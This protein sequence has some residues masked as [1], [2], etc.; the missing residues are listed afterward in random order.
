MAHEPKQRRDVPG[1]QPLRL[2]QPATGAAQRPW[3]GD[4]PGAPIGAPQ[5]AAPRAR[6]TAPRP[7]DVQPLSDDVLGAQRQ[8]NWL[9]ELDGDTPVDTPPEVESREPVAP[10]TSYVEPETTSNLVSRALA[11]AGLALLVSFLAVGAFTFWSSGGGAGNVGGGDP[12]DADPSIVS[13]QRRAELVAPPSRGGSNEPTR[14]GALRA[15]ATPTTSTF[16]QQPARPPAAG[17]ARV[18]TPPSAPQA[19]GATSASITPEAGLRSAVTTPELELLPAVETVSEELE[20]EPRVETAMEELDRLPGV[21]TVTHELDRLPAVETVT[22]EHGGALSGVS[23]A[24]SV[25]AAVARVVELDGAV[26]SEVELQSPEVRMTDLEASMLELNEILRSIGGAQPLQAQETTDPGGVA[27]T[28][29]P[30]DPSLVAKSTPVHEADLLDQLFGARPVA[31]APAPPMDTQVALETAAESGVAAAVAPDVSEPAPVP[32]SG[33]H[34]TALATDEPSVESALPG[35]RLDLD[36]DEL[37]ATAVESAPVG[38]VTAEATDAV[39]LDVPPIQDTPTTLGSTTTLDES[40]LFDEAATATPT[41]MGPTFGWATLDWATLTEPEPTVPALAEPALAQPA[42][43]STASSDAPA[44]E[45]A[46]SAV[47]ERSLDSEGS[48]M[49]APLGPEAPPNLAQEGLGSVDPYDAAL[50]AE[51]E[52]LL[53]TVGPRVRPLDA[54]EPVVPFDTTEVA[55]TA[56][57]EPTM[58][59]VPEAATLTTTPSDVPVEVMP[60]VATPS[61]EKGLR[62]VLR[63]AEEAGTWTALDV[64]NSAVVGPELLLTPYTGNVRVVF[65]GGDVF[66]GRLHAVGQSQVTLDTR[67]GRMTLDARRLERIERLA[68][69]GPAPKSPAK[70]ANDTSGLEEV[71]VTTRGGGTFLGHLVSRDGNQVTLIVV[72]GYRLTVEAHEVTPVVGGRA[73]STLRRTGDKASTPAIPTNPAPPTRR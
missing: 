31:G 13:G 36:W 60:P 46:P 21:E 26:P 19:A 18:E 39:V 5:L 3:F 64:P 62:G 53:A 47:L 4:G 71:R 38:D 51:V 55:P 30:L 29:P 70:V 45:L 69:E 10:E 57:A 73:T 68:P 58:S 23:S 7:V 50:A 63:R 56:P 11:P 49:T 9:L 28:R 67:L 44:P 33:E 41:E 52:S 48:L 14:V 1:T 35:M 66:E 15:G 8:P 17:P 65:S 22:Q 43:E 16:G 12:L 42:L 24:P 40:S 59:I 25:G 54:A 27:E 6:P 61:D 20:L 37:M 2:N 72:E 34:A 32:S